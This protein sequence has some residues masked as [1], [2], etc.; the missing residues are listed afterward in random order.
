MGPYISLLKEYDPE[1]EVVAIFLT[2]GG[3]VDAYRRSLAPKRLGP[4]EAYEKF[5]SVL[6]L[7]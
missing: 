3:F 6:N 2:P 4:R 7:T 1:T 5:A